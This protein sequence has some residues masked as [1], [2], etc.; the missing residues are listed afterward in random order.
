MR[1]SLLDYTVL[2]LVLATCGQTAAAQS[3]PNILF[4]YTDD[5][6]H[7]TVGAY[8]EAYPWVRT[9]N[10]DALASQSVRFRHAYI[11]SWCMPSRATMLT[12]YHQHGIQSMRMEGQYPPFTPAGMKSK[13]APHDAAVAAP[14]IIRPAGD[15]IAGRVIE[16]PVSGVD[17]PPTFFA[18]AG[19]D[20][21]WKMHGRDLSP[22]LSD[23][24]AKWNHAAMLVHT[25]KQYGSATNQIPDRDDPKLYHGPGIPWYVMLA[26]DKFKYVRNLVEGETEEL[27]DLEEDPDELR[28]LVTKPEYQDR[29]VKFRADTI[30]ELKRTRAGFVDNMPAVANTSK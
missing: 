17:L 10:I 5:Q 21:P 15:R 24:K 28:N 12:G 22:L 26:R 4:I 6:S 3:R 27:Y 18:Q 8:S 7:R 29:L 19:I 16:D 11:G 9:P 1:L 25:G 23:E 13:V 30:K 20:L 2:L 14:M